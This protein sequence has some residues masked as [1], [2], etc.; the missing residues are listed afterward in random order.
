[1]HNDIDGFQCDTE[2]YPPHSVLLVFCVILDTCVTRHSESVANS[3]RPIDTIGVL[4]SA[5]QE[6]VIFGVPFLN[7][8]ALYKMLYHQDL[9]THKS[10]ASRH[11]H[12]KN[13]SMMKHS[14][15]ESQMVV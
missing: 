10:K 2:E 5:F 13:P 11:R 12:R 8:M 1:M 15:G 3:Y 7:V 4:V 9:L 14:E 6:H